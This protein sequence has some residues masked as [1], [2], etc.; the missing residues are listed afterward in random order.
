MWS[1]VACAR[2]RNHLP[3][4]ILAGSNQI[5]RRDRFA[6]A[7]SA[8]SAVL[9][10]LAGLLVGWLCLATPFVQSFVPRGRPSMVDAA[11]SIA[12]W[13]FAI[14]VPA[15]FLIMGV[16]R[17]AAIID[18]AGSM[19]PR[20]AT[21]GLA[22]A[23]GP[24]YVGATGLVI[25]GGRRLHELVLGPFGLLVIAVVPPPRVTRHVGN[26]WEVR[27]DRGRWIPIEA[28]LDRATRDAERVRGWLASD[29]RDFIVRVYAAIVTA[30][31]TVE[32]S[33]ACA[34]VAPTE[35]AAWILALPAQRGLNDERRARL[36]ETIAD[37]AAQG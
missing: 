27:D 17:M 35:L 6:V 11:T 30:D 14:V 32:R 5:T 19:R 23:L 13:G 12:A 9:L 24:E 18:T 25:P 22:K 31:T 4:Q 20:T 29:D 33:P 3:M 36:A 2:E 10:V 26:L 34:V 16:A 21:S 7:R 1:L 28:P 15:A 8:L 37:V